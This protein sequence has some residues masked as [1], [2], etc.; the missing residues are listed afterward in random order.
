MRITM[1]GNYHSLFCTEVH[2][3][4]TLESM[5]HTVIRLQEAETPGEVVLDWAKNS[6]LFF[7]S[8]THGWETPGLSMSEVLKNLRQMGVP[9]MAYHLD[10][11]MPIPERWKN[12]IGSDYFEVEHF[13]TVDRLMAEWLNENTNCK[14]HYLR[15]GVFKDECIQLPSTTPFADVVFVGSKGYH[16]EWPWRPQLIDWLH[17]TYGDRFKHV[18]GD[19]IGVVRGMELNQLLAN[20]KVVVG[21]SLCPNFDYPDYFSDRPFELISRGAFLLMPEIIGL[22]KCFEYGKE[23]DTFKFGEFEGLKSK[24]DYY[25]EHD[26]EREKIRKAGFERG[27][28]EHTYRHRWTEIINT[29]KIAGDLPI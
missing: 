25:L 14:G 16:P 13:F 19:G 26:E 20:T 24:I 11:Y 27:K 7:W 9:S 3:A 4:K 5:G 18:G 10:L 6:D 8:K 17:E 12:Y 15:A 22:D 21:D 23:I 1:L 2:Y 29:L 28:N